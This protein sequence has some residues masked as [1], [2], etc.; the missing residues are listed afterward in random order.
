MLALL[1]QPW[2]RSCPAQNSGCVPEEAEQVCSAAT[3]CFTAVVIAALPDF[4]T[5]A[6][7]GR[8]SS[9]RGLPEALPPS[10]LQTSAKLG[11]LSS[12]RLAQPRRCKRVPTSIADT[13]CTCRVPAPCRKRNRRALEVGSDCVDT[14]KPTAAQLS[15]LRYGPHVGP[16]GS[17]PPLSGCLLV[18]AHGAL[19]GQ[20][21]TLSL[22][23]HAERSWRR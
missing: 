10:C 6:I 22:S 5:I 1:Q 21:A 20:P 23:S 12:R 16:R 13:A 15:V 7:G 4:V 8:R 14:A 19:V 11:P 3:A 18:G 2:R 17:P 9:V